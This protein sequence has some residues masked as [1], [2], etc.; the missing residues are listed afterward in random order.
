MMCQFSGGRCR[1]CGAIRSPPY[2]RRRCTPGLGDLA[3]SGLSAI[4]VTAA[5]ADRLIRAVGGKSCGCND[6]RQLMNRIGQRLGIGASSEKP[7]LTPVQDEAEP[8]L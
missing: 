1:V 7:G 8:K 4:G 5:R 3:A 6:R 2:P